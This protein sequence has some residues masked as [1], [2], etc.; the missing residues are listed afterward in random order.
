MF[1]HFGDV[2]ALVWWCDV[3]KGNFALSPTS[4]QQLRV[5]W[6]HFRLLP[7]LEGCDIK[8]VRK[9]QR[10]EI[11]RHRGVQDPNVHQVLHKSRKPVGFD[12]W[13]QAVSAL[14]QATSCAGSCEVVYNCIPQTC[15]HSSVPWSWQQRCS[16]QTSV[17]L[18]AFPRPG[19]SKE[20]VAEICF[21]W[22]KSISAVLASPMGVILSHSL[23]NCNRCSQGLKDR[24]LDTKMRK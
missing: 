12:I 22:I 9:P 8:R 10:T 14:W 24:D 11:L 13:S 15:Y 20:R 23:L 5:Q 19:H 2:F 17:P 1:T 6:C 18:G 7:G 4:T 3:T 16:T 21:W